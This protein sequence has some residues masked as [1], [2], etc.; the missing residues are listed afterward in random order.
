MALPVLLRTTTP[1]RRTP[2]RSSLWNLS[3]EMDHLFGDLWRAP[4]AQRAVY[5]PRIDLVETATEIRVS[6]EL[7]G[8]ISGSADLAP[9]TKTHV[10]ASGDVARG[11]YGE[12]NLRF[13]VREHAMAAIS[14]GI[15]L[16]GTLRPLT[17][18]GAA[19]P[20]RSA[21]PPTV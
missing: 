9:S 11:S 16:D 21:E 19:E 7:P 14:N 10:K 6:A 15:A 3:T 12:R 2:R 5:A 13:G 17:I 4:S 8:L 18:G 1:L 20:A